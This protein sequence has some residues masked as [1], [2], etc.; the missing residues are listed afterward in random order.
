MVRVGG[1]GHEPVGLE[2]IQG[3]WEATGRLTTRG[4]ELDLIWHA[5]IVGFFVSHVFDV[6]AYHPRRALEDPVELLDVGRGAEN[7]AELFERVDLHSGGDGVVA[8]GAAAE[9]AAEATASTEADPLAL[10]TALTLKTQALC[11]GLESGAAD[12]F[13]LTGAMTRVS[14]MRPLRA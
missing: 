3:S 5:V 14:P 1:E 9:G 11:V 4:L 2:R 13:E 10:S 12:L 6:L 8:E 7:G